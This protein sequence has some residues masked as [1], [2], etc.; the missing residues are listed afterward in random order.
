M[1]CPQIQTYKQTVHLKSSEVRI[2]LYKIPSKSLNQLI[3]NI[4]IH[5]QRG[6]ILN[7]KTAY[8]CVESQRVI[9]FST[10]TSGPQFFVSTRQLR[11]VYDGH[12]MLLK[13]LNM[14]AHAYNCTDDFI[15]EKE[16]YTMQMFHWTWEKNGSSEYHALQRSG[17]CQ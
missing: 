1:N 17:R 13:S 2:C 8:N 10:A 16:A 14:D 7:C 15:R 12:Y 9:K 4:A 6:G 5:L 3:I 11:T